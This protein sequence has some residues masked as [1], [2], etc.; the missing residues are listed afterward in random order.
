MLGGLGVRA[1]GVEDLGEPE[2]Q[3]QPLRVRQLRFLQ[4]AALRGE[5]VFR[6][7]AGEEFRQSVVRQREAG[8][9]PQ[10]GAEGLFRALK[11][12]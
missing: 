2:V 10:G 6:K 11:I 7:F 4:Q 3:Q 12:A 1:P 8:I 5:V 9:A